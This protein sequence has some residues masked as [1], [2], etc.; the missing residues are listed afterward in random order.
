ML[1]SALLEL[2]CVDA[3]AVA[4]DTAADAGNT[5]V[6]RRSMGTEHNTADVDTVLLEDGVA[7]LGSIRTKD[8]EQQRRTRN[9]VVDG[10]SGPVVVVVAA[11]DSNRNT[12][13]N[14]KGRQQDRD[15]VAGAAAA[16]RCTPLDCSNRYT[17]IVIV[18]TK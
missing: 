1:A 6:N 9:S 16:A 10:C 18:E 11:A 4:D 14:T 7:G 2:D 8:G 5:D 13:A 12:I 17:R 15:V 3:A